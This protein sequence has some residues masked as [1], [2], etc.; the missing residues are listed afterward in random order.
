MRQTGKDKQTA[1]AS[2]HV[3]KIKWIVIALLLGTAVFVVMHLP[4]GFSDDLTRIGKGK[5]A[6]VLV[7][8]KNVTQ[9]F[10]LMNVLDAV[11]DQY[12]GKVEFLLTDF[13]T[14][15]GRTF[16]A[17][18][19]APRA[20]VAMFDAGGNLIKILRAPQTE[21]S[22]RQEISAALGGSP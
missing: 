16:V 15:Q 3:R 13:D 6:L 4:R 17:A 8:D 5:V 22:M 11:R 1:G 14:A 10:D 12:A 9:S 20:T 18:N 2:P 21:E 7:R 19:R